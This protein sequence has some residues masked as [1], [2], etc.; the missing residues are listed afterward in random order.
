MPPSVTEPMRVDTCVP[1]RCA[2]GTV[3]LQAATDCG[4]ASGGAAEGEVQACLQVATIYCTS[5]FSS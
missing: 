1:G 5:A 2:P 3:A 4:V